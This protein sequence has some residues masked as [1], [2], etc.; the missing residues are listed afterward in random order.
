MKVFTDKLNR[1]WEISL[2]IGSAKRVLDRQGVNLLEI[3]KGDPP[4]LTRIGTE[5]FLLAEI[6]AIL[7]EK[8]FEK[9]G[10]NA[11]EIYDTFDD[12]TLCEAQ[13]AFYEEL[14]DFFRNRGRNDREKA[15]K[16]Q[17]EMIQAG[18]R[19]VE[20]KIDKMD[21]EKEI[22]GIMSGMSPV[23]SE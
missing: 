14:I 12:V 1:K 13:N 10:I 22:A 2:T 18:I 16:K 5:E 4:L 17:M 15:V 23:S 3:E 9:A 11:E 6:L 7:L 21:V 20:E 8:Q 19:A